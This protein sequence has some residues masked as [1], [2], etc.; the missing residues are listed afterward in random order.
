[1]GQQYSVDTVTGIP[2]PRKLISVEAWTFT[3]VFSKLSWVSQLN[4]K[5]QNRRGCTVHW[6][7]EDWPGQEAACQPQGVGREEMGTTAEVVALSP[8]GT[9][10][11][12]ETLYIAH[13]YMKLCIQ[14]QG[15]LDP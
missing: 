3:S 4:A 12:F 14:I 7:Q 11:S 6:S 1:M 13:M 5:L 8:L 2:F 10:D 9:I 15:F